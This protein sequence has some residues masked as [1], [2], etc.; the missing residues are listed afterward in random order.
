MSFQFW[1]NPAP[2]VANELRPGIQS[3]GISSLW[4]LPESKTFSGAFWKAVVSSVDGLRCAIWRARGSGSQGPIEERNGSRAFVD[5][6]MLVDGLITT[7]EIGYSVYVRSLEFRN[8]QHL[9]ADLAWLAADQWELLSQQT[10]LSGGR[11]G[12][13]TSVVF[14]PQEQP[15]AQKWGKIALGQLWLAVN[16][17]SGRRVRPSFEDFIAL[18]LIESSVG[19]GAIPTSVCVDWDMRRALVLWGEEDRLHKIAATLGNFGEN[20]GASEFLRWSRRGIDFTI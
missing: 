6:P 19:M 14:L 8:S 15:V 12:I 10:S 1:L 18:N 11:Y 4:L 17:K 2:D 3:L 20:S 16:G 13:D 9:Y 7:V 5:C